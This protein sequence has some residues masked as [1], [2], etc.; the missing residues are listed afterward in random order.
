[1]IPPERRSSVN[2]RLDLFWNL[3]ETSRSTT[4]CSGRV[5]KLWTYAAPNL[6]ATRERRERG[7]GYG[8]GGGELHVLPY[9]LDL[10]DWWCHNCMGGLP[11]YR[12]PGGDQP[13]LQERRRRGRRPRRDGPG[14][15]HAPPS[16]PPNPNP[17]R[18]GSPMRMGHKA[19]VWAAHPSHMGSPPGGPREVGCC[20]LNNILNINSLINIKYHFI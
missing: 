14:L 12:E 10:V 20:L 1:M 9:V 18:G 3:P 5:G 4:A 2:R 11:L 13:P 6:G 16:L 15:A 19:H 17:R 8:A 7:G